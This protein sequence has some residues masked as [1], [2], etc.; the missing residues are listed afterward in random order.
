MVK[1]KFPVDQSVVYT[2][3]DLEKAM[4]ELQADSRWVKDNLD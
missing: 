2:V 1:D 3:E 4:T